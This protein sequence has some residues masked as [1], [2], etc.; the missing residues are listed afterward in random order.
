MNP[1]GTSSDPSNQVPKLEVTAG[2]AA[3]ATNGTVPG[4]A[5]GWTNQGLAP[6]AGM[7][8]GGAGALVAPPRSLPALEAVK[9]RKKG[10][11]VRSPDVPLLMILLY[12]YSSTLAST[13]YLVWYLVPG[14][15]YQVASIRH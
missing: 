12:S 14:I 15:T 4:G 13:W 10:L 7:T 6:G 8:V 5:A 11:S 9:T 2:G 1:S 3:H